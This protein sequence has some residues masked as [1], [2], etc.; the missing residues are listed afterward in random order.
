MSSRYFAAAAIMARAESLTVEGACPSAQLI[1]PSAVAL[2]DAAR[3]HF[4][5]LMLQVL[6]CPSPPKKKA[7]PS[8]DLGGPVDESV[9][10][11]SCSKRYRRVPTGREAVTLGCAS[12][13]Q[14]AA[15]V[16]WSV[17]C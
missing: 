14:G 8:L 4:Q 3:D 2:D 16:G 13:P 5:K 12:G 9:G 10:E 7:A 17:A 11:T 6:P 1:E 15:S